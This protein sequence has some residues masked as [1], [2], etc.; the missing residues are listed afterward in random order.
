MM[1]LGQPWS[2][3]L[4]EGDEQRHWPKWFFVPMVC[5]N[6]LYNEGDE[7]LLHTIKQIC[8]EFIAM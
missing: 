1:P 7:Y 8:F 2:T 5:Q 3:L 6:I 4:A